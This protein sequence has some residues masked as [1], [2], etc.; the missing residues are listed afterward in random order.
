MFDAQFHSEDHKIGMGA[1]MQ[2]SEPATQEAPPSGTLS[3]INKA[4]QRLRQGETTGCALAMNI[5][6]AEAGTVPV[7]SMFTNPLPGRGCVVHAGWEMSLSASCAQT[8]QKMPV[9]H[10]CFIAS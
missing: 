2:S 10:R 7:N 3:D 9:I 8:A 1:P 5:H 6:K 4:I